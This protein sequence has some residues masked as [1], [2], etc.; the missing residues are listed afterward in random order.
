[1]SIE[2]EEDWKVQFIFGFLEKQCVAILEPASYRNIQTSFICSS[3]PSW[4]DKMTYA[5]LPANTILLRMKRIQEC[6]PEK[7]FL[8][9]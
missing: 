9:M 1:M 8:G 2:V 3:L 5:N 6:K 4:L 7:S